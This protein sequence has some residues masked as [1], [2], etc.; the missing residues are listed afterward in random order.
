MGRF[1]QKAA[2]LCCALLPV[3]ATASAETIRLSDLTDADRVAIQR[4]YSVAEGACVFA[5]IDE[6]E[7]YGGPEAMKEFTVS[8]ESYPLLIT[9]GWLS[10]I[11]DGGVHTWVEG[12]D[13]LQIQIYDE[14][15]NPTLDEP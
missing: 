14:D 10:H 2:A 11:C 1:R 13:R 4:G 6:I 15:G 5:I 3:A 12:P 7:G 8:F 9:N